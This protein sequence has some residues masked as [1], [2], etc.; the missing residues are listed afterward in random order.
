MHND[1]AVAV[2]P[3]NQA[4]TSD[5]A[6]GEDFMRVVRAAAKCDPAWCPVDGGAAAPLSSWAAPNA[7]VT[8]DVHPPPIHLQGQRSAPRLSMSCP[9]WLAPTLLPMNV[10]VVYDS[11]RIGCPI[12]TNH[13]ALCIVQALHVASCVL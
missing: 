8:G 12:V 6:H 9:P 11:L 5:A 4:P 7:R 10:W 1:C 3:V 13:L 2:V